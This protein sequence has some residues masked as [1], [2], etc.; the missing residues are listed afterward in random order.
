MSFQ[1]LMGWIRAAAPDCRMT[2]A[3]KQSSLVLSKIW[4]LTRQ[5]QTQKRSAASTALCATLKKA[6]LVMGCIFLGAHPKLP[7]NLTATPRSKPKARRFSL[8]STASG[9][10]P[11][12]P[13][14]RIGAEKMFCQRGETCSQR[15]HAWFQPDRPTRRV[16][17]WPKN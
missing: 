7:Q 15:I 8:R 4:G 3:P 17:S 16:W 12:H 9:W 10:P 1:T 6:S 2:Y 11:V 14:R 5:V 13:D